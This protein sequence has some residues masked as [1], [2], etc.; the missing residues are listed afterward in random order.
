MGYKAKI[1]KTVLSE[2]G[3][4]LGTKLFGKNIPTNVKPILGVGE[5]SMSKIDAMS[6]SKAIDLDGEVQQPLGQ[7]LKSAGDGNDDAFF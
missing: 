7:L 2:W 4:T 3:E 6:F 5:N 1:A